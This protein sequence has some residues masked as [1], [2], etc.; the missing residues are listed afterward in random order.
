MLKNST[1]CA[2][3]SRPEGER[4]MEYIEGKG[5]SHVINEYIEREMSEF[6]RTAEKE[7]A[8][9]I[10]PEARAAFARKPCYNVTGMNFKCRPVLR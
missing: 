5:A 3:I 4:V 8:D 2:K 6:K 1:F 9:G 7:S 10:A